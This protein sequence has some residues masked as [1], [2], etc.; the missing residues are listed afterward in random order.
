MRVL[1]LYVEQ[2]L[3]MLR[4][5]VFPFSVLSQRGYSFSFQQTFSFDPAIAYGHDMIVLP[6]WILTE[7]ELPAYLEA[8]R[9]R[10]FVYDLSDPNL[11]ENEWVRQTLTGARLVTVPNEYLQKEV[12]A[13]PGMAMTKVVVT[14][15]VVDP[16]YFATAYHG[17]THYSPE[18]IVIGC[19]GPHDWELVLP[20]LTEL[21][22]KRPQVQIVGDGYAQKVLGELIH[23]ED[24]NPG[25]YPDL[26]R[27][28][29]FGLCP[30]EGLTGHDTIWALEYGILCKP[31]IASADSFYARVLGK[32]AA[33][34]VPSRAEDKWLEAIRLWIRDARAR[35]WAGNLAFQV[36]N[37]QRATQQAKVYQRMF[38][39]MLPHVALMV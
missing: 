38:E 19:F 10:T 29:T 36:A 11:L 2:T 39:Q 21:R 25:T 32:D 37:A 9:E 14:P 27:S 30:R 20:A 16:Q 4:R 7:Q 31:V 12:R 8:A 15:S 1:A 26:L 24:L 5:V 3:G 34:L 23:V 13:L 22:E 35:A 33:Q 28:C 17:E 18:T 6:N